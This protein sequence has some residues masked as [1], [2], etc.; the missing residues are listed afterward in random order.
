ME[1]VGI[2]IEIRTGRD[3]IFSVRFHPYYP[4]ALDAKLARDA[5]ISPDS[6]R[7][8][9]NSPSPR[10]H[11]SLLYSPTTS[12]RRLSLPAAAP[13]RK[14]PRWFLYFLPEARRLLAV[15]PAGDSEKKLFK[16]NKKDSEKESG[17]S[18]GFG[19]PTVSVATSS[20]WR[21]QTQAERCGFR[22]FPVRRV[23]LSKLPWWQKLACHAL[24]RAYGLGIDDV[25]HMGFAVVCVCDWSRERGETLEV[26]VV[27]RLWHS[28]SLLECNFWV[29]LHHRSELF[30]DLN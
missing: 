17:G 8:H 27:A 10:S 18:M 5:T 24:I 28:L 1:I 14:L 22:I 2:N 6:R 7:R 19:C 26:I 21:R 20:G 23:I 13:L 3:M 25:E 29:F 11:C 30:K 16:Q 15:G 4:G 12:P 9:Q